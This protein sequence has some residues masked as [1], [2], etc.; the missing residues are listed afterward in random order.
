MQM[1]QVVLNLLINAL[2]AT[3]GNAGERLITLRTGPASESPLRFAPPAENP[4][5]EERDYLYFSVSDNGTGMDEET[6]KKLPSV[7]I[8]ESNETKCPFLRRSETRSR[9]WKSC[10][11]FRQ[12]G[13]SPP[14]CG[15]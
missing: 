13:F 3:A 6:K 12:C 15:R 1:Q 10:P 9:L 8:S 14:A 4:G 5:A 2:D 7:L 11:K